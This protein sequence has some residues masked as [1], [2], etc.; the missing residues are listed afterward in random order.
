MSEYGTELL[1]R[2]LNGKLSTR[3]LCLGLGFSPLRV[4]L[5]TGSTTRFSVS[6]FLL[7][8][9]FVVAMNPFSCLGAPE[10]RR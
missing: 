6:S 9:S 1:R 8:T 4:E 3:A 7:L 2:Q 5:G 10:S